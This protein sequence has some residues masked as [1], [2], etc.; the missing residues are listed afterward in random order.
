MSEKVIEELREELRKSAEKIQ[1]LQERLEKE[2][3]SP[4]KPTYSFSKISESKLEEL[5]P[6]ERRIIGR[7]EKFQ[8]WFHNSIEISEI[9]SLFLKELLELRGDRVDTYN[10]QTLSMKFISAILNRVNFEI[11]EKRVSDFYGYKLSYDFGGFIFNGEPDFFVATGE[12]KPEKPYFFLQEF[13]QGEQNNYPRVQLV[14]E[15][16]TAVEIN[17]WNRIRGGYIRGED[18]YFVILEKVEES[19]RYFVSDKFNSKKI[20]ELESIFRNL[21]FVKDEILEMV[22]V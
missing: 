16:I 12:I 2:E 21:L 7:K 18:W 1:E 5:L 17:G 13:K 3:A 15:L 8:E 22:D 11:D 6:I 10:E 19:Y 4:P 9:D 20:D 14:A